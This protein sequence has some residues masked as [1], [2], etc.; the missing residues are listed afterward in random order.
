M[1]EKKDTVWMP[2]KCISSAEFNI[3]LECMLL[4]CAAKAPIFTL[5]DLWAIGRELSKENY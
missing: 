4:L 1:K 5:F 2:Q 3:Y